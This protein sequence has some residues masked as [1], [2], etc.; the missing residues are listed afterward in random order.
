MIDFFLHL[1]RHIEELILQFGPWSYGILALIVFC[2]TGLVVAPFLPGDSLLFAA[3]LF[4]NAGAIDT[5][6][7]FWVLFLVL[8]VAT[9]LGDNVNYHIGKAIGNRILRKG[10]SR[11]IKKEYL[12]LTHS[13][14]EE[15]GPAAVIIAR[16]VPIVRTFSPFVCGMGAMEYRRFIGFSVLGAALWVGVCAGGGYVFGTIPWVQKNFS[17]AILLIVGLSVVLGGWKFLS[18]SKK[19]KTKSEG[20]TALSDAPPQ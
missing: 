6:L 17:A 7:N 13:F 16:F 20:G 8:M 9:F 1:D 4:C 14:L 18:H 11:L 2:E 5:P 19:S 10:G 3:G 15:H 12:E